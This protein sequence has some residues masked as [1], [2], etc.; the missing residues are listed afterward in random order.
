MY[1]EKNDPEQAEFVKEFEKKFDPYGA[2]FQKKI[3]N[4]QS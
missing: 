4:E 2:I 1:Y 3:N